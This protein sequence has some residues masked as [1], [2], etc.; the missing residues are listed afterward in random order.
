M[1]G[2]PM[3][4]RQLGPYRILAMLGAGG[5]GEVYRAHDDRLDRDVALKILPASTFE[6]ATAR[7]RLVRE[8]RA[9]AAL[10]H[11]SICTIHEVGE[12]EGQA[13]IAMELVEGT[14]LS[15]SAHGRSLPLD[16]VLSYGTQIADALAHAHARGIVHRDLKSANVVV[17]S[18]KRV[19]V[20]DFGLAKKMSG[21]D[22]TDAYTQRPT[23]ASLTERGSVVG[24]IAYM[25][26]EQLRGEP[27]DARSDLWAL[28]VML[29]ELSGGTKPFKGQSSFEVSS[30]ILSQPPSPFPPSVPVA[31]RAVI[32]KCLEKDPAR[33]Y[34]TASEAGAS[35]QAVQ[36]GH[37]TRW[38]PLRYHFAR[39]PW[40]LP[41]VAALTLAGVVAG[42]NL[43]RI[44]W[45][46]GAT[47]VESLAVLPLVNLSGDSDQDYFADG[48]TEVLSTDLA[49]LGG[50]KRVIARGSVIRYKGTSRPLEEIARELNV[51]ALV[52]GSVLR[53]G[54]RVSI[55]AQLLDPATG[56][57]LWTNRYER[58]LQDVLVLRSEI[59]SAIVREIRMKLSP[60]EA[61]RLASAGPVNTEAFEAYLKG[62]FHWLKQTRED[63]DLAERY[64]QSALDKDP[65]YALAYAGLG[66]VW[67]MRGDTGFQPPAETF[68]K[69][70]AFTAKAFELDDSLADLH[71]ALANQHGVDSVGLGRRRTGVQAGHRR[72]SESRRCSFLL[73]R[74]ASG[75]ETARRMESRN[76]A[77]AG[78]GSAERF[79]SDLLRL[80][81]ELL[82]PIRRGDPDLQEPS[83]NGTE[84]SGQPP[85]TLGGLLPQGSVRPG[86]CFGER[87]ISRLPETASSSRHWAPEGTRRRTAPA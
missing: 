50:L 10:N 57:Q 79:Q 25:A 45:Q 29:Y 30:N 31:L 71:V 13:Y 38:T 43:N 69:A 83:S 77:R 53:S 5:M 28:G 6:D 40:L 62:R 3:I 46:S 48:M 22:L 19:K 76:P 8:A 70:R 87:A 82:G 49:R 24:T 67:M 51:D 20:L 33:R 59:V 12:A 1:A 23:D 65:T 85:R 37:A 39:R 32:D 26:P 47:G 81:L 54:D 21:A 9:A 73:L 78:T 42:L 72:E 35:L 36:A 64:F 74:P 84:Q 41:A 7:A 14:P 61:A 68:P 34:Q 60:A 27:A 66:S 18:D 15:E 11:A 52:T 80:A 4:G 56:A 44:R 55:T 86:P 63:F 58:S 16:E 17:T 2:S 75:A